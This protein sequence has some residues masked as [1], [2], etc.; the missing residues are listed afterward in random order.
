M[1]ITGVNSG[2]VAVYQMFSMMLLARFPISF[3]NW[4]L[5][6]TGGG[7]LTDFIQIISISVT[8][9]DIDG[10]LIYFLTGTLLIVAQISLTLGMKYTKL[11]VY[12]SEDTAADERSK[13]NKFSWSEVKD[14]AKDVWPPGLIIAMILF[15]MTCVHPSITSLVMS[16]HY[17]ESTWGRKYFTPVITF[18]LSDITSMVGRIL[19]LG[20][21]TKSNYP[22]WIG[23]T[24]I[25]M[26]LSVSFIIFCNAQPRSHLSVVFDK[27]WQFILF[28]IIF[29]FSGGLIMNVSCLS[30]PGFTE[31]NIETAMK[32]LSLSMTVIM[33]A[34]SANGVLMVKLL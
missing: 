19:S 10:A 15:T 1:I 2:T 3:L 24:M 21:V 33:A 30:V 28:I 25:R 26:I 23:V 4:F 22:I 12:Y 18:L 27:D 29:N 5:L 7:I 6:G 32:L 14:V 20:K 17:L 16:Q 8:D 11:Y 31:R 34:F 9:S 13:D